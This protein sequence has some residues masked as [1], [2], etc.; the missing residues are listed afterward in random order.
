MSILEKIDQIM[1]GLQSIKNSLY[2]LIIWAAA[3]HLI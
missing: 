3:D 1:M 2:L